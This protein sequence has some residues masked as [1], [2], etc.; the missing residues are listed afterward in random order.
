MRT[1][2]VEDG[3][4]PLRD[5]ERLRVP[6][7]VMDSLQRALAEG[8]GAAGDDHVFGDRPRK[9]IVQRDPARRLKATYEEEPESAEER[10]TP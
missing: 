7:L 9:K 4:V 10:T 1:A 2:E 6:L 8:S 5:R 3:T